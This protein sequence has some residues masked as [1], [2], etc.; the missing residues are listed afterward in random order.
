VAIYMPD[1]LRVLLAIFATYRLARGLS[2]DVI[3][4][5]IREGLG[6]KAAVAESNSF[7][8]YAAELVNCPYCTGFWFAGLVSLTLVFPS[9]YGDFLLIWFGLAGAQA[10]LE[11]C[12]DPD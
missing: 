1:L 3:A 4:S 10:F 12:R 11:G 5:R 6:R 7:T 2:V 9:A 8:F